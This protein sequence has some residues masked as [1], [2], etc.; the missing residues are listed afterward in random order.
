MPRTLTIVLHEDDGINLITGGDLSAAL[1]SQ[2]C[3]HAFQA[4]QRQI[5]DEEAKR[6]F[7]EENEQQE[8]K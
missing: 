5:A 7:Q 6:R 8:E 2:L 4:F 3:L 1:A